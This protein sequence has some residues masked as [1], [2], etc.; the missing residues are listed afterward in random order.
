MFD[1]LLDLLYPRQSLS[2]TEGSFITQ[3]ER[4][5]IRLTPLLLTKEILRK[6]GLRSIDSIVAAGRYDESDELKRMILTYKYKRIPF[7]ADDL[8]LQM[9]RAIRGLLLPDAASTG[10]EPVLCPV[11]LHWARMNERGFNQAQKLAERIARAQNLRMEELL[12]RTRRTGHQAHRNR[13]ER[14]SALLGAFAVKPNVTVPAWVILIDD[15]STTGATLEECAR[16]L[17]IAGAK[18]VSGLTA[19]AG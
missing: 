17:K 12:L 13:S 18:Q 1:L 15:L 11:P 4:K 6:R 9:T 3:I 5:S 19:A 7:F 2:G 14:L 8:A 16:M 10:T